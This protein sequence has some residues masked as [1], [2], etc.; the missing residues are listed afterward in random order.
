M[1]FLYILHWKINKLIGIDNLVF[2]LQLYE[3]HN[4][5][6]FLFWSISI[7]PSITIFLNSMINGHD[8][9]KLPQVKKI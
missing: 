2:L 4:S 9:I 3:D 8:N 1:R 6:V 7:K 5:R